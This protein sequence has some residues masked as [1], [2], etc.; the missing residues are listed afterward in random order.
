RAVESERIV[1]NPARI[2]RKVKRAARREVRPLAPATVE[3]LR[4]ASRERD[5]T[6][7][8]VLAYAGLRPQE[9]LGMCW[10]HVRDRTLLVERAV[11]L[12]ELKDT[13]TRA[14]RTVRLLAPLQDDLRGWRQSCENPADGALVFPSAA[15][16]P[17]TKTDWD[18]W[19]RRAFDRACVAIALEGARPYDLRHSFASLLLHEGRSVMYVARQLGHDARL[20]LGTYGH[21]IDGSTTPHRSQPR[22]RSGPP[23]RGRVSRKEAHA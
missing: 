6:L 13:K 21:V 3:K 1:R 8:A 9:A 10:G 18:N 23:A 16:R 17:W 12:G 19:R 11:S 22:T 7:I 5:A 20:T 4:A 14:H 2:V 15:D